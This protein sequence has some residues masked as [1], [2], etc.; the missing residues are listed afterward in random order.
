MQAKTFTHKRLSSFFMLVSIMI[1]TS[2]CGGS[3]SIGSAVAPVTENPSTDDSF[4][5]VALQ[6]SI[7]KV[8]PMTGIVF[9]TTNGAALNNLGDVVQL[10]YSYMIYG[11]IVSAEGVYDWDSVDNLLEDVAS[12]GHQAIL[13][14]RYAYPGETGI[15][16][17]AYIETSVGYSSTIELVEGQNTYLPDWSFSGLEDFTLDFFTSFA[18]R[19]DDD[20]R[21]AFLQIGF[22]SYAEYH[23]YDGTLSLG[24]NF[25]SKTFQTTFL[26]HLDAQFTDVHWSLSIDSAQSDYS[27]I[28]ADADLLGLDFGLFDD[29]FMHETHSDND[30]EYNRASW[31]ALGLDKYETSPFGGEFSYYSDFD[32][33]NVL[34]VNTGS[35]GRSFESFAEQYNITYMLGND[36]ASY[37]TTAR[38]EAASIATGYKFEIQSFRTSVSAS[39][40]TIRNTGIAPIYYDAYPAVNGVRA[41]ESLKG[42]LPNASMEFAIAAGGS[43]PALTIE[44]DRLVTGQVIQF[45]AN[46]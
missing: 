1:L 26:N 12:R 37:Q 33:I 13:R 34:N 17:P 46:L 11:D 6:S 19:Y 18:E 43:N 5:D 23:L 4:S 45:D 28:E 35:H 41:T 15:S 27:P 29:S 38:I 14:F 32:Q 22:G 9:W 39:Q 24:N 3:P 31:L 40:L 7:D 10:E 2:A 30:S 20:A 16:V 8:Q 44:S 42:L 25:P 21:L 36:Q